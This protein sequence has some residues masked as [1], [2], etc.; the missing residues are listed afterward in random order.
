[1]SASTSPDGS[2]L[3]RGSAR[4]RRDSGRRSCALGD[5]ACRHPRGHGLRCEGGRTVRPLMARAAG[6]RP[7]HCLFRHFLMTEIVDAVIRPLDTTQIHVSA[8]ASQIPAR[9]HAIQDRPREMFQ[10]L[11]GNPKGGQK[12]GAPKA[13]PAGACPAPATLDRWISQPSP[14]RRNFAI[15]AP[16]TSPSRPIPRLRSCRQVPVGGL[17]LR[18]GVQ[19]RQQLQVRLQATLITRRHAPA[20]STPKRRRR[21]T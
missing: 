20:S 8:E 5:A 11:F 3:G 4:P 6:A 10:N 19:V 21:P 16:V 15:R 12:G 2:N 1:M 7:I 17:Q 18:C 14:S 13:A 9:T